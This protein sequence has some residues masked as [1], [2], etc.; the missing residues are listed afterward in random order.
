MFLFQA[1]QFLTAAQTRQAFAFQLE[2][3]K[4]ED[5]ERHDVAK[6][7][8]FNQL[9]LVIAIIVVAFLGVSFGVLITN[10]KKARGITWF[11]E[12]FF[13]TNSSQRRSSHRRGPDGQEM[14][15]VK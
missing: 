5:R 10:R 14:R 3:I 12:G 6:I 15:L 8:S 9:H 1:A 11:P 7:E 13:R 4:G 2:E